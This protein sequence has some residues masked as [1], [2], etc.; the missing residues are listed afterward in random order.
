MFLGGLAL[1]AAAEI[2]A[3]Q[4]DSTP[5]SE[6]IAAPGRALTAAE[7][8]QHTPAE[9]LTAVGLA[10][11]AAAETLAR[12][13]M[14]ASTLRAY[15]A[16]WAH[17]ASWCASAGLAP[18][19]AAPTTVAG[20]LASLAE[21]HAPTTLRRRLAAL[22]KMHRFNNLPWPAGHAVIRAT[23][24]GLLRRHGRPVEKAA[25]IGL[26]AIQKL[27]ATCGDS[28]AGQRDRALLLIGFA[29]ALR[30]SEL[31]ALRLDD[32]SF[33]ATG[34]SIRIRRS[35][36][37]ATGEG[38]EIGLPGGQHAATCPVRAFET[39]WRT[40]GHRSG[41]VFRRISPGGRI[42]RDVLAPDA[43]RRIL[44]RRAAQADLPVQ[45]R[46]RLTAHGL[47]AGCITEAYDRGV[48]DEDIM[49]H[50]RH[51]DLKTMRGYV[52]RAQLRESPA[53]RLGL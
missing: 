47:R 15:R 14:A 43:V 17:F 48:R 16:D 36:T 10:A 25:A 22:A 27:V 41:P 40:L 28:P 29:G 52:R 13:A 34:L 8:G 19:P 23:L 31:V 26:S 21:S 32:V 1:F 42:G 7:P 18:I 2:A 33:T 4:G 12:Q 37:D 53:G 35:K 6:A 46:D 20:Y 5:M 50:S 24:R 39:W 3:I 51:R 45:G 38:A 30:R 49:R 44:L 11:L 9:P